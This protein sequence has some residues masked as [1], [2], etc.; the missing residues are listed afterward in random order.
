MEVIN[1]SICGFYRDILTGP[2]GQILDD[3]G[4]SSNTIVTECRYFIATLLAGAIV[5]NEASDELRHVGIHHMAVGQGQV[6]WD[7]TGAP[8]PGTET[9]GLETPYAGDPIGQEELAIIYLDRNHNEVTGPTSRLQITATL[10]AGY[11]PPPPE[12][13]TYPL[14]E[15]GLFGYFDG[16]HYMINCVRHPVIPKAPAATLTRIVRLYF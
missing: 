13:S 6:E 8:N 14:R 5:S 11:P 2:G 1:M 3:R 12:K 16:K 4:W 7:K 15:F 9:T 10:E